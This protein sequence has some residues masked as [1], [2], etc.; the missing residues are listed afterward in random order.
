MGEMAP[1][2]SVTPAPSDCSGCC[3]RS[4][5]LEAMERIGST[6]VSSG[7]FAQVRVTGIAG[8][9]GGSKDKTMR[10]PTSTYRL[11]F[12]DGMTF[13][14]AI[15]LI[16]YMK[17]LGISD[18][19]ASPVFS[20]TT[21]S[22]HGYDVTNHNEL[23][24]ALGGRAGFEKLAIAL[25]DA[26]LGLILDI[27]PNHMAASLENPWWRDV[28]EWGAASRFSSAF[29]ID[30]EQRLT[31]PFLGGPFDDELAAGNIRLVAD[32]ANGFLALAC[33]GQAY[34]LNPSTYSVVLPDQDSEAV[35]SVLTLATQAQAEA[36]E[37]FHAA[38]R[39]LLSGPGGAEI[40]ALIEERSSDQDFMRRLHDMQSYRL[41]DWRLAASGLSYR[42]F[43]EITGLVGVRVE[44]P[45]VFEAVHRTI[46][47]LLDAG[48][49]TGL[50][51]DH[52]D[53][54][55]D[56]AKYLRDLRQRI[57]PDRYLVI[58]K[59]LG[60]G[61]TLPPEWPVHGTTGYEFITALDEHL[62]DREGWEMLEAAYLALCPETA[63]PG[64][65]RRA[66]KQLMIRVNFGGEVK[67]LNRL[68]A[69]LMQ[70]ETDALDA[71]GV[72]VTPLARAIEELLI[73][74]PIYR[75]Y[76]TAD[77]FD[78]RD[79]AYLNRVLEEAS[80]HLD[81]EAALAAADFIVLLREGHG[82]D[83]VRLRTRLQQLTGPLMAKSLEDTLFY[84]HNAFLAL[85]EVGGGMPSRSQPLP[86]FHDRMFEK[87]A[88]QPL[89]LSATATH[90]TKRG[91]DARARLL[92]LSEDPQRWIE[93]VKRW[94]SQFSN[95]LATLQGEAVPEPAWQW[96]IFQA[97]AG[98]WP[99]GA[100]ELSDSELQALE[101]RL[102]AFL[103]K[104]MREAKLAS[105]W[106]A[107]NEPYEAAVKAY[108]SRL[109]A[110]D[111]AGFRK[112]F[113]ETL[114]PFTQAGQMNS[115]TQTI[116]KLTAPG[117]PDIY[118][119]SEQRDFSFVD[120]DNRRLPD[121]AALATDLNEGD[122]EEP[123][124]WTAEGL[125]NGRI[126]QQVIR[127]L[128]HWRLAHPELF[129]RGDYLPLA[130]EG[131]NREHLTGF[132]RRHAGAALLVVVPR[133]TLKLQI[134]PPEDAE[135]GRTRV[136]VPD[137]ML[138]R[139]YLDL[140]TGHRVRFPD[141]DSEVSGFAAAGYSVMLGLSE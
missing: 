57:G 118:Q 22:T 112:D 10:I 124:D 96:M 69:R 60:E 93:G 136:V 61:E 66:A 128:L 92:S 59:I 33:Y 120:P 68:A 115:L 116:L 119:G 71:E 80:K 11:Q 65:D 15:G 104:A 35:R 64:G 123:L 46:F 39:A 42:R 7:L 72:P 79:R 52:V 95:D 88:T 70:Q 53:G 74:F 77:G 106:S 94:R 113:S 29:D 98:A 89:G 105:N 81:P 45:Q 58:E 126:K 103:E 135:D 102:H 21:G 2:Q 125:A 38:M 99:D 67:A 48:L 86:S 12:R 9:M 8:E 117:I 4:I 37:I 114:R 16:P 55:A 82:P 51:I 110:P 24:P 63:T 62:A 91:E 84:R 107:V 34:P 90:D 26:G 50:R 85:N 19:Y 127:R 13:E 76:G 31:L 139:T 40:D 47:D 30:W 137:E 75:T 132:L 56:P 3:L 138:D 129:H 131:Q 14:R 87:L 141:R 32:R 121:F 73:A 97:L 130:I 17:A 111:N 54:L 44:D 5:A 109:M 20:A 122:A 28:V 133:W 100:D 25:R 134:S 43:F 23:D 18:L 108:A 101:E 1:V 36:E 49:V 140:F 78:L 27:V 41:M 83:H 6:L